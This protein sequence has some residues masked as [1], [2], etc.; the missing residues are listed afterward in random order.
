MNDKQLR[1]LRK[2]HLIYRMNLEPN[3]QDPD[4]S[5]GLARA[6][7]VLSAMHGDLPQLDG[8]TMYVSTIHV[9][10]LVSQTDHM[11]CSGQPEQWRWYRQREVA[12][13][14][15]RRYWLNTLE[16]HRKEQQRCSMIVA[17]CDKVIGG[18]N[19]AETPRERR[20]TLRQEGDHESG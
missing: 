13:E 10:D 2:G 19:I 16:H 9:R 8:S 12:V 6:G 1:K 14:V 15:A 4:G 3:L 18:N 17:A 5:A 7:I 11:L 20:L